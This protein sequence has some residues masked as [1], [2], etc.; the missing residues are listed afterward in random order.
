MEQPKYVNE[1]NYQKGK[2]TLKIIGITIII[3]G[4]LIGGA[5]IFHGIN[6]MN[7]KNEENKEN[8]ILNEQKLS[9]LKSELNILEQ[10]LETLQINLS[11]AEIEKQKIFVEDQGFSD[12]YYQKEEEI[13]Q[14]NKERFSKMK[15][16]NN[17][18]TEI[19]EL[20]NNFGSFSSL[21]NTS[22]GL[23]SIF[24]GVFVIIASLIIGGSILLAVHQRN[25]LA[26]Q[27]Q[28]VLPVA[29]ETI[30]KVSPT[31]KK[32]GEELSPLYGTIAKEITKGIK[33]GIKD[34]EK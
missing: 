21:S 34:E 26:W 25:I 3:I 13:N 4:L 28:S 33:E 2:K 10:E 27:V 5:L 7:K 12:R 22:T 14:L 30:E 29:E 1:S 9:V 16:K 20:E 6:T 24:P 32:V 17:K 18:E 8:E 23:F 11:K 15:E 31:I 19:W